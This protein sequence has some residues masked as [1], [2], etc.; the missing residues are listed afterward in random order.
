[1]LEYRD[2]IFSGK[3]CQVNDSI[4]LKSGCVILNDGKALD[5]YDARNKC[6]EKGGDLPVIDG[7][8]DLNK[9]RQV[10]TRTGK[11]AKA[12]LWLGLRRQWWIWNVTG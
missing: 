8:D 6:V 7:Q 10:F 2:L 5:F 4:P 12:G 9:F 3:S 1:M 11:A